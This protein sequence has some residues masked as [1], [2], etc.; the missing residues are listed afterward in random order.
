MKKT[1]SF[2]RHTASNHPHLKSAGS[3]HAE[4]V[5]CGLE[6]HSLLGNPEGWDGR[7]GIGHRNIGQGHIEVA[8]VHSCVHAIKQRLQPAEANMYIV[9]VG[10]LLGLGT[11]ITIETAQR[12]LQKS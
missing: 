9:K 8:K 5:Q 7:S 4:E 6:L 3:S 10:D 12:P 1:F 2:N 11:F